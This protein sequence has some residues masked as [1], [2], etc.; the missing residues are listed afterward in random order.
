MNKKYP[1][2]AYIIKLDKYLDENMIDMNPSQSWNNY[3][4]ITYDT[5]DIYFYIYYINGQ[6]TA[7]P[8]K[9]DNNTSYVN[10]SPTNNIFSESDYMYIYDY[11]KNRYRYLPQSNGIGDSYEY[12]RVE[13]KDSKINYRIY[14]PNEEEYFNDITCYHVKL[15]D[16]IDLENIKEGLKKLAYVN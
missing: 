7:A 11:K 5:R 9:G 8:A 2:Y 15:L 16:R 6:I 14:L 4:W 13:D 12:L 1:A 3:K 10:I